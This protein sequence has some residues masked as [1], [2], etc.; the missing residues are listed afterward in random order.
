MILMVQKEVA[1]RICA[2]PGKMSIL[3]IAVQF[4]AEPEII[5]IVSKTSFYPQPKVDSAII[6]IS[7]QKN[8]PEINTEKFF[9]MIRA[10][11]SAK[12]KFLVNNLKK[13]FGVRGSKF[14]DV[15]N[16]IK[17]DVKSRAENLS[18]EDWINIYEQIKFQR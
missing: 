10:G 14:E 13:E 6:K 8:L 4:Y 3:A 18:V 11:F 2:K 15:F 17:I 1:E 9:K 12:R 16:K 7:P 5:S